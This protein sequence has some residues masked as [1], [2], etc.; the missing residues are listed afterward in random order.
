MP[1]RTGKAKPKKRSGI[2]ASRQKAYQ[3]L[4]DKGM[5]VTKAAK[6]ANKGHTFEG[7]SIMAR[8]GARKRS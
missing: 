2:V 3:K 8:K 5:S 1:R 4:R 6:I 7:R